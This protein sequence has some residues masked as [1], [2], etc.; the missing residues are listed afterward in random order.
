MLQ[1]AR[2]DRRHALLVA[3]Y[4]CTLCLQAKGCAGH[5]QHHICITALSVPHAS[6]VF[7]LEGSQNATLCCDCGHRYSRAALF[8]EEAGRGQAA[9][10]ALSKG[11]RAVEDSDPQ[12]SLGHTAACPLRVCTSE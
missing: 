6:H 9:A 4:S 3:L 1:G 2:P 11:A 5:L 8:Y 12:A 7:F 10:E